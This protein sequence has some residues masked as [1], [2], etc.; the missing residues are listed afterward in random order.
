MDR[1]G[2]VP[3]NQVSAEQ[4]S[5]EPRGHEC[6]EHGPPLAT[7]LLLLGEDRTP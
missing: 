1:D 2:D 5:L 4:V 3:E 7:S 6:Q